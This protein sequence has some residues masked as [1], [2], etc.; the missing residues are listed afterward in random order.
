MLSSSCQQLQTAFL[1][2]VLKLLPPSNVI[3]LFR[4]R[5]EEEES[6]GRVRASGEFQL[7]MQNE[8]DDDRVEMPKLIS[9]ESDLEYLCEPVDRPRTR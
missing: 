8:D 4:R 6:S 3:A 1:A 9:L 5:A 2:M 7:E